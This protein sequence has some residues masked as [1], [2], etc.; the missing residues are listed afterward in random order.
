[1]RLTWCAAQV[2]AVKAQ[3]LKRDPRVTVWHDPPHS[4]ELLSGDMRG[5]FSYIP[6]V[7]EV[8]RQLYSYYSRSPKRLRGL[9]AFAKEIGEE[10]AALHYIFE[11]RFVESET[12][13]VKNF[14]TDHLICNKM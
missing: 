5:D 13:A 4:N 14:L 10:L 9:E 6:I 1:M 2:T 3:L 12:V 8:I 11:V 7:H